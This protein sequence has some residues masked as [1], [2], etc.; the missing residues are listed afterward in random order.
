MIL[1]ARTEKHNGVNVTDQYI[2]TLKPSVDLSKHLSSVQSLHARDVARS[3]SDTLWRGIIH[4]YEI[5]DFQGYAAH[6]PASTIEQLRKHPD[7]EDI[8]PDQIWKA[9]FANDDEQDIPPG[10]SAP[11][12][13]PAM[14]RRQIKIPPI[15]IPPKVPG[16]TEPLQVDDKAGYG[17]G[18]IS[19]QH[20]RPGSMGQYVYDKSAGDG[21]FA[22]VIGTG[23][24]YDHSEFGGRASHGYNAFD[25]EAEDS[26]DEFGHGTVVAGVIGS[27]KYGVAK[28]CKLIAIKVLHKQTGSLSRILDGYRWAV[29]DMRQKKRKQKGVID[30]TIYGPVSK[31]WDRAVNRAAGNGITTVACA[32]DDGKETAMSPGSSPTSLTVSAVNWH[33]EKPKWAN[34]GA[35][36]VHL[37]AYGVKC[38]STWIGSK[39]ATAAKSG[40]SVAAGYVA[41]L[42]I[43]FKALAAGDMEDAFA[44]K[45]WMLKYST[46]NKAEVPGGKAR[47]AYNGSGK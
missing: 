46:P 45:K 5:Y 24:N 12:T 13:I 26:E 8:E 18:Y 41:G 15:V 19:H 44:V 2:V 10:S 14:A 38:E 39:S 47:F 28:K 23:I 25:P 29:T 27:Q 35:D 33:C 4:Q 9:T 42:V 16:M 3:R 34:W 43:Y 7:I 32:G 6:M 11:A 37:W 22:Y 36:Y 17:L 30:V 1:F 40:T 31:A 21:T 20:I